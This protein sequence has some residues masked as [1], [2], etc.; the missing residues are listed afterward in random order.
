[1]RADR[2]PIHQAHQQW[3][4][5]G[6]AEAADGMALVT[7][8]VRVNQLL[9]ERIDSV[10]RPMELT[11]ARYEVLRLLSFAAG[12]EMAMSRMG[13][14]LQV[15]PTSVTSLVERLVRQGYVERVR[16]NSDGRVVLASLTVTGRTA[17]EEAT[18]AL[19]AEVFIRP[20]LPPEQ[21]RELTKLLGLMR[22]DGG[23]QVQPPPIEE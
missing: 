9:A 10:L 17:V 14:L 1:M 15:H 22:A 11:F 18:S 12:G 23:D 16:S 19:N 20:G 21:V 3:V 4:R 5:H 8:I 6:W 2:D 7:S 13:S